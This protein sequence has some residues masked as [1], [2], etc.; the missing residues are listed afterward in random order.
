MYISL[1]MPFLKKSNIRVSHKKNRSH[2]HRPIRFE[3]AC[4]I[5]ST[6]FILQRQRKDATKPSLTK[7]SAIVYNSALR[8]FM[9]A[10]STKFGFHMEFLTANAR[11]RSLNKN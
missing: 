11:K 10:W 1:N 3:Q 9:C 5:F 6:Y 4:A 7:R 2:R 8:F